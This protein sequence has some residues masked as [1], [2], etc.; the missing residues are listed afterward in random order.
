MQKLS[1]VSSY[2]HHLR[3]LGILGH[4]EQAGCL[5][6]HLLISGSRL[7]EGSFLRVPSFTRKAFSLCTHSSSPLGLLLSGVLGRQFRLSFGCFLALR[8]S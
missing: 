2:L 6:S 8:C 3:L 1:S 7:Y 4:L 5:Q